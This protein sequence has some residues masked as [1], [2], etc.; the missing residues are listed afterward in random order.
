LWHY[1][2]KQ[3]SIFITGFPGLI[4]CYKRFVKKYA[5][6][7]AFLTTLLKKD[8]FRWDDEIEACFKRMKSLM[9][10]TYV[11]AVLNFTKPFGS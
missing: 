5:K 6:I 1:N 7:V 8:A 3:D 11:L 4:G 9:T 10:S 2:P